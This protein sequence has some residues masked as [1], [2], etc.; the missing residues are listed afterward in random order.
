MTRK[1]LAI[2]LGLSLCL[3]VV[4]GG[5]IAVHRFR[6]GRLGPPPP[7]AL[8]GGPGLLRAV[9]Q[10]AGGPRDERVRALRERDGVGPRGFLQGLHAR[11]A[12]VRRALAAEPFDSA[13][14]EAAL[15]QMELE[16]HR[17][18]TLADES[19]LRMLPLLTDTERREVVKSLDMGGRHRG[20]RGPL[21]PGGP[22]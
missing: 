16:R 6:S 9:L 11:E 17:G 19:T 13:R 21:G 2:G 12:E 5:L 18:A 15:R 10:A 1:W 22:R 3:N 20:P 14:L 8:L 4:L 7:G